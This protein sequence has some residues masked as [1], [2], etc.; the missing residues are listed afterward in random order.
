MRRN[1]AVLGF[2]VAMAGGAWLALAAAQE[3]YVAGTVVN[4]VTGA[5]VRQALV[6]LQVAAKALPGDTV[7]QPAAVLTDAAGT[8]RI[9]G[10]APGKYLLIP[11]KPGFEPGPE[12]TIE[13]GPSRDAHGRAAFSERSAAD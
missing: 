2:A 3:L 6:T 8:F 9:S 12:P 5:P 4:S 1:S 13:L 7:P 10:V 11:V